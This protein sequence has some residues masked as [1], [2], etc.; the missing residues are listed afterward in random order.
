MPKP[1]TVPQEAVACTKGTDAPL[2]MLEGSV[3]G[4]GLPVEAAG[5][6]N[7]ENWIFVEVTTAAFEVKVIVVLE[8]DAPLVAIVPTKTP[9]VVHTVTPVPPVAE[10]VEEVPSETNHC[11]ALE[12]NVNVV[13]DVEVEPVIA[14]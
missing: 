11:G 3:L 4:S 7:A 6:L 14:S 12:V 1:T 2:V 5:A 13:R 9:A 10:D 8:V